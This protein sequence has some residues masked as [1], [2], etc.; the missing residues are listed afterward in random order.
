MD[1]LPWRKMGIIFKLHSPV[2][3]ELTKRLQLGFDS[4]N[5]AWV[6]IFHWSASSHPVEGTLS[7]DVSLCQMKLTLELIKLFADLLKFI[8]VK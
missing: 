2:L 7:N 6:Q 1:Q 5:F 4:Q 8:E 3:F